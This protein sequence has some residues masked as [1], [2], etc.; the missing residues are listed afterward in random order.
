[1]RLDNIKT[2]KPTY[3]A[4]TEDIS[5]SGETNGSVCRSISIVYA[6][7]VIIVTLILVAGSV[8]QLYR[9]A[10]ATTCQSPSI[11]R[12]WRAFTSGERLEFI[13]AVNV[14]AQ[15]TSQRRENGTIY[16]DFALLH[17]AISRMCKWMCLL[18]VFSVDVK[19]KI[20]HR[21]ASFLPWHRYT[22]ILYEKA[23]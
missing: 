13:R 7:F 5:D 9:P 2:F 3:F 16:D 21:S 23:L 1:M 8:A 12:E 20:V 22:L 6:A 14:L 17:G 11:R 4:L 10:Q 15:V 18:T 19:D